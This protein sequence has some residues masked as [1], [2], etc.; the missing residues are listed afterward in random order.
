[1]YILWMTALLAGV[2]ATVKLAIALV[3]ATEAASPFL[4]MAV[5]ADLTMQHLAVL[6]LV[7]GAA[8]HFCLHLSAVASSL[9]SH[10]TST[11]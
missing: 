1:M 6:F 10:F 9:N 2:N 7:L 5:L 3:S 8:H 11:A 4:N